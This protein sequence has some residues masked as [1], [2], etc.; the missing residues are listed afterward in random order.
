MACPGVVSGHSDLE[1][2]IGVKKRYFGNFS[3][4]WDGSALL[5]HPSRIPCWISKIIFVLKIKRTPQPRS[6]NFLGPCLTGAWSGSG[7]V[8]PFIVVQ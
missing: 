8:P 1:N 3:E 5:V 6:H 7:R 4:G 2:Q